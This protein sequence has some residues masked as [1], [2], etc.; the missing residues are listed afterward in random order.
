MIE[1]WYKDPYPNLE[2]DPDPYLWLM[3][4]DPG[5]LKFVDPDLDPDPEHW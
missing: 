1:G 5:G 2:P 4:T 3:D